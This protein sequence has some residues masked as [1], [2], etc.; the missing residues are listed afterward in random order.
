MNFDEANLF[1]KNYLIFFLCK[2]YILFNRAENYFKW[3]FNLAVFNFCQRQFHLM[4]IF[5]ISY[6][7][8]LF[9]HMF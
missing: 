9:K 2:Y 1:L 4:S 5:K 3:N 6:P 7:D 8:N